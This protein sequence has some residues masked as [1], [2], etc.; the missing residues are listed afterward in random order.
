VAVARP[1]TPGGVTLADL[2]AR[3]KDA[4]A[5]YEIPRNLLEWD[6]PWPVSPEGK[7]GVKELTQFAVA[8]V[9]VGQR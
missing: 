1:K 2:K 7:L 4:L 5:A 6:G 9:D 8:R 3:C